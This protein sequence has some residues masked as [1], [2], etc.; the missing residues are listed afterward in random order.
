MAWWPRP[1][2]VAVPVSSGDRPDP[3]KEHASAIE[4]AGRLQ[5]DFER[6]APNPAQPAV[7][8]SYCAALVA[9]R[10]CSVMCQPASADHRSPSFADF[11]RAVSAAS[12]GDHRGRK[13]N[14]DEQAHGD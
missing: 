10:N 2:A 8:Q 13:R 1:L 12:S 5:L 3:G 7:T 4:E 11:S 6:R 9:P 14:P